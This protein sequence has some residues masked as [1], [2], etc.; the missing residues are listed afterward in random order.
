M[1]IKIANTMMLRVTPTGQLAHSYHHQLP[2]R[3]HGG[4]RMGRAV[5]VAVAVVIVVTYWARLLPLPS[6]LF[7]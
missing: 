7:L 2:M 3:F 1:I 5:M 4:K 6:Q